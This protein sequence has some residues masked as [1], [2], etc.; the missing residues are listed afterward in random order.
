MREADFVAI[1]DAWHEDDAAGFAAAGKRVGLDLALA[2]LAAL[3]ER[4]SIAKAAIVSTIAEALA[5]HAGIGVH[6]QPGLFSK[7]VCLAVKHAGHLTI[8]IKP[9]AKETL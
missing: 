7:E 5:H 3:K 1:E 9:V 8:G 2:P 6:G 4:S